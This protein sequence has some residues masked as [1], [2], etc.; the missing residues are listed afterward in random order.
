MVHVP[1]DFD[2]ALALDVLSFRLPAT[3]GKWLPVVRGRRGSN[4]KVTAFLEVFPASSG[5]LVSIPGTSRFL[6]VA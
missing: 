2:D 5:E 6:L 4:P 3:D 1:A